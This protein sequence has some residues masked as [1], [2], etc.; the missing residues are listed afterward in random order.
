MVRNDLPSNVYFFQDI[1]TLLDL[2]KTS[3][4][5]DSD[6]LDGQYKGSRMNF[7]ND[8]TSRCAT[9]FGRE[10]STLF[11]R[12]KPSPSGSQLAST[13]YLPPINNY[14][15]SILLIMYLELSR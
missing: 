14:K 13:H 8:S 7:V 5:L 9:S 10:F 6:F 12:I 2:V 11:G 1:M 3:N 15:T 4:L